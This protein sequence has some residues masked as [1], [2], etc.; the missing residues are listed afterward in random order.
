MQ[1][2]RAAQ[3]VLAAAQAPTVAH[4][5]ATGIDGPGGGGYFCGGGGEGGAKCHPHYSRCKIAGG[6][7]GGGGSSYIEPKATNTK[8]QPGAAA[9]SSGLIAFSWQ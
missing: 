8:N 6:G 1:A 9:A 4:G 2:A 3:A 7:S 5:G